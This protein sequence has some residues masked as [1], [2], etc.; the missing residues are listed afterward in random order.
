M[1][2]TETIFLLWAVSFCSLLPAE[3]IPFNDAKDHIGETRCVTGKVMRVEAGERGVHYLDFCEDYRL[4]PFTVVVFAGDLKHVG[5]VRQLQ[6]RLV[7][8][9]GPVKEYDGRAEIVLRESR[10]LSGELAKIPPLP[11]T[12]DAERQ[13]HYSAG[14]FSHPKARRTT[15][16][17]RNSS[18]RPL[19]TME[20]D[21]E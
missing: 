13:G 17:R 20:D 3:C 6:G 18:G 11:K 9:H 19:D 8:I 21:S 2:W 7:E 4:C 12:Y 15:S 16:K 10:Q 1:R 14:K 5:D